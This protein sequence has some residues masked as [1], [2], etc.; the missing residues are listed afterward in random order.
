MDRCFFPVTC[1]GSFGLLFT[2]FVVIVLVFGDFNQMSV[3][4]SD[5]LDD[6]V[7]PFLFSA[8]FQNHSA[9]S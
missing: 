1:D 3:V 5:T 2:V 4:H 9:P 6:N 7:T 8:A